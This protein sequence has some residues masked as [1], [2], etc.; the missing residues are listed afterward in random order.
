MNVGLTIIVAPVLLVVLMVV[1]DPT[2]ELFSGLASNE[3][4]LSP[5][6]HCGF[7]DWI[8]CWAECYNR[9]NHWRSIGFFGSD[10]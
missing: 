4:I 2:D 5:F 7:S 9:S 6:F 1:T 3:E 10:L 8:L